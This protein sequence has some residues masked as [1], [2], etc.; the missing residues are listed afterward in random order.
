MSVFAPSREV[1][2]D[3]MERVENILQEEEVEVRQRTLFSMVLTIQQ[4]NCSFVTHNLNYVIDRLM[5]Y[6]YMY[7][8]MYVFTCII[9]CVS[10]RGVVPEYLYY[11]CIMCYTSAGV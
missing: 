8:C 2:E 7:V 5:L 11:L 4:N 10:N 6:I 9:M 1:M 3:V